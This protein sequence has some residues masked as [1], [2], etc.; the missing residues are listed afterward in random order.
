MKMKVPDSILPLFK[1][2]GK[3]CSRAMFDHGQDRLSH[4]PGTGWKNH[5]VAAAGEFVGTFMFLFLAFTGTSVAHVP[6]SRPSDIGAIAPPETGS[7]PAQ[8]LYIALCFGSS[9]AINVWLFYRISGGLFN[10][11]VTLGLFLIDGLPWKRASVIFVAQMVAAMVSAVVVDKLFPSPLAV[12]TTLGA[13]TNMA[14]GVFIEA[15]LTFE[16]VFTIFMLA[17]EKH[18]ATFLAPIGIGLA[19]FI[20]ELAGVYYTG[21]SLNPARSFGPAVA[22]RDFPREHWIYWVGPTMGTLAAVGFYVFVKKLDYED[23]N[24]GQD[25]DPDETVVTIHNAADG[26]SEQQ[27]T[28]DLVVQMEPAE[29]LSPVVRRALQG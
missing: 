14:Q 24:P 5:F 10:P 1:G 7:N 3:H 6:N 27:A 25:R 4:I 15:F 13:G 29:G 22:S 8:L 18:K 26:T 28:S 16:L 11:C 9:L 12:T 20:A 23:V 21:G 2:R 17:V 19:L